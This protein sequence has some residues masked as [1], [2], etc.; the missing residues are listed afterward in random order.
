MKVTESHIVTQL[1]MWRTLLEY[2]ATSCIDFEEINGT[3]L[4]SNL[5]YNEEQSVP[6]T[7]FSICEKWQST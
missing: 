1:M 3:Y 5:R 7:N 2:D 6:T 4:M